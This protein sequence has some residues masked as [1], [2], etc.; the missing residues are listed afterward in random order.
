MKKLSIMLVLI[1]VLTASVQAQTAIRRPLQNRR[2]PRQQNVPSQ[3]PKPIQEKDKWNEPGQVINQG[4]RYDVLAAPMFKFSQLNDTFGFLAG[5]KLGWIINYQYLLGVEGYWLVNDVPGPEIGGRLA[6]DLAMKYGGLTLEYIVTPQNT[7]HFSVATLAAMG[8]V[9]YDYSDV[10]DD[11]TYWVI[12]PSLNVYLN[13]T[14][15]LKVGL[16][17][18]YRYVSDVDLGGLTGEDLSGI[19]ATLSINF[20]SYGETIIP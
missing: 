9:A 16:G 13:M 10:R 12:E 5:G 7:V 17:A 15:Y 20:G 6:P 3:A 19:V 1:L 18:G 14:Q 8:S 11:D 4:I 2:T